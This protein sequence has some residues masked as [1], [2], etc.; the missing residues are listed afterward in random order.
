MR[1]P[2]NW[3]GRDHLWAARLEA[4]AARHYGDALTKAVTNTDLTYCNTALDVVGRDSPA[5]VTVKFLRYGGEWSYGLA[6]GDFPKVYTAPAPSPH[7]Y[8]DGSLCLFYPLDPP[9][10]RWRSTDGLDT[11][12][13]LVADHLFAED[14]WHATGA[15]HGGHWILDEAPHGVTQRSAR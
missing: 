3:Y 13:G 10:R 4:A 14:Y 11:L 2:E 9:W 1:G 7:R 12:F 8:P 15:T 5:R 6:P